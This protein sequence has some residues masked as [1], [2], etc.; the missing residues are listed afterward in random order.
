MDVDWHAEVADGDAFAMDYTEL[1]EGPAPVTTIAWRLAPSGRLT[2]Q[3]RRGARVAASG[4][5]APRGYLREH[6]LL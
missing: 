3:T 6:L 2:G 5:A 1:P 4:R